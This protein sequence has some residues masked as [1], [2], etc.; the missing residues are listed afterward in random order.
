MKFKHKVWI[1]LKNKIMK[2]YLC[3]EG[4]EKFTVEAKDRNEAEGICQ[5]FN[6]VV[7]KEIKK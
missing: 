1:T 6:A 2:T 5:M 7:I 3:K 4:K